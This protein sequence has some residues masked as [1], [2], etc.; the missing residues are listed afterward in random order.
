MSEQQEPEQETTQET[1]EAV[2]KLGK[3]LRDTYET[4]MTDLVSVLVGADLLHLMFNRKDGHTVVVGKEGGPAHGVAV[5]A[6]VATAVRDAIHA[7]RKLR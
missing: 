4:P 2:R 3:L 1:V 6:E 7:A 5:P